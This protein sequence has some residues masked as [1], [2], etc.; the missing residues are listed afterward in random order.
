MKS[1]N[2]LIPC[3][4]TQAL[5]SFSEGPSKK[6]FNCL[7]PCVVTQALHSFSEGPSMKMWE[8]SM[9]TYHMLQNHYRGNEYTNRYPSNNSPINRISVVTNN[10]NNT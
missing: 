3:V 9:G 7:I 6:S 8:P 5:G 1:F 10:R 4:V 2:C